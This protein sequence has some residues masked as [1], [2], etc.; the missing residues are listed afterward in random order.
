VE[1]GFL[2]TKRALACRVKDA[3]KGFSL[4]ELRHAGINRGPGD[5][6]THMGFR[7]EQGLR[8]GGFGILLA[9]MLVDE[10]I[11]GEQGNDVILIKY[12]DSPLGRTNLGIGPSDA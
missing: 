9:K 8:D 7:K 2:R 3:G 6:F 11:Y 4:E 12:V 10:I 5:L 1:M